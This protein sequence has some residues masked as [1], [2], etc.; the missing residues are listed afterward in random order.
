MKAIIKDQ[1]DT[2]CRYEDAIYMQSGNV[3]LIEGE[4]D[5]G[6]KVYENVNIEDLIE[7]EPDGW[8]HIYFDVS[9]E[10]SQYI[11]YCGETG[12]GGAGFVVLF[13][14]SNR[15]YEWLIHISNCNNLHTIKIIDENIIVNSDEPY[16]D[17]TIFTI[18]IKNP[19]KFKIQNKYNT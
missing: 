8:T 9:F 11:A 2:M 19:E 10:N 7:S 18:P 1:N 3:F 6:Y 4:L 5:I 14:K 15:L 17:G 12:Y 16:P 13:N